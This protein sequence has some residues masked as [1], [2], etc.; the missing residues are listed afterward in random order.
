MGGLCVLFPRFKCEV[1]SGGGGVGELLLFRLKCLEGETVSFS[2]A[3]EGGSTT[4]VWR[5]KLHAFL[6]REW[7]GLCVLFSRFK[8]LQGKLHWGGV[9]D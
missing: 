1:S 8:C 4:S 2:S 5:E 7:V 9:R 3:R 6:L